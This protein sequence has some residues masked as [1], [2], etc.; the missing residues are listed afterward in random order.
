ML[1]IT[2]GHYSHENFLVLILCHPCHF[3]T[4]LL[5]MGH[6]FLDGD[7]LGWAEVADEVVPRNRAGRLPF[8]HETTNGAA[9]IYKYVVRF[10]MYQQLPNPVWSFLYIFGD[11]LL[12]SDVLIFRSPNLGP[13]C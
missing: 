6:H 13:Q 8:S 10:E 1:F 7:E 3:V 11:C 2:D 9:K 12:S 5:Y 4:D